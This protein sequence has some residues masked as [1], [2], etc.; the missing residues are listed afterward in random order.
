MQHK[1]AV[2]FFFSTATDP[3]LTGSSKAAVGSENKGLF[4]PSKHLK[5]K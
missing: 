2:A 3:G 4:G 5:L 1:P